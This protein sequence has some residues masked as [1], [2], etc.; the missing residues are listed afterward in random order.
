MLNTSWTPLIIATTDRKSAR[1]TDR[2]TD[3]PEGA[4]VYR[5]QNDSS[6]TNARLQ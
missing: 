4:G 5:V 2:Q 6:C 1:Q 3:G